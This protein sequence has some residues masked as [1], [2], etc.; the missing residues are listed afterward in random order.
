MKCLALVSAVAFASVLNADAAERRVS[1]DWSPYPFELYEFVPETQRVFSIAEG[2]AKADG[3]DSAAAINATIARCSAAGGGRVLVPAGT[4]RTGPVV[5]ASGVELHL[6]KGAV[7]EVI[8][9]SEAYPRLKSP[10][11][12]AEDRDGTM[13][14][15]FVRADRCRNVAI[16]GEG[17]LRGN[18]KWWFREDRIRKARPMFLWFEACTNIVLSGVKIRQAAFW[19]VHTRRCENVILR[20]LDLVCTPEGTKR[21]TNTDGMDIDSTRKVLIEGCSFNQ[22]DD[23][24]CMKSGKN[25]VGRRLGLPTEYVAVRNCRAMR[26]HGLLSIGSELSGGIRYVYMCDCEVPGPVFCFVR[27]KT[28]RAR[29]AFAHDI[30]VERVK[31][32]RTTYE[33]FRLETD[34][35]ETGG[36]KKPYHFTDIY[37]IT[38]R[39][40]ACD[41][42]PYA[43]SLSG[44]AEQPARNIRVERLRV[45]KLKKGF[46]DKIE[47]VDLSWV[48][49]D[50][51]RRL[52]PAV[53]PIWRAPVEEG[54]GAFTVERRGKAEGSVI[55]RDGRLVIRKTNDR[56]SIVVRAKKPISAKAG[57]TVR[58]SAK[59]SCANALPLASFASPRVFGVKENLG[60]SRADDA[61]FGS[62]GPRQ[63]TLVNTPAGTTEPKFGEYVLE[64]ADCGEA[65]TAIVVGGVRS[66]SVWS[67][68]IA[69]TA[70]AAD[71]AWRR[72]EARRRPKPRDCLISDADLDAALAK[73]TEHTAAVKTVAG[74]PRLVVDGEVAAPV[75]YKFKN[76]SAYDRGK[77]S[78][79]A[80]RMEREAGVDLQAVSVIF[81]RTRNYPNGFWT[82]DSFD[83]KGAVATVREAMR[84]SPKA[85][86]LVS[87]AVFPYPEFTLEHPD[88]AW[89]VDGGDFAYGNESVICGTTNN[90]AAL[91]AGRWAWISYA[92]PAWRTETKKCLAAF[93][94][95]LRR[96]GTS[97]RVIGLHFCG[98]RD[99]QFSPTDHPDRS[100]TMRRA[101]QARGKGVSLDFFRQRCGNEAEDD[102]AAFAKERF[103]KETVAVRWCL[104]AFN[105][106]YGGSYDIGAFAESKAIDI[107]C[108]QP[109]YI[110]RCP[111][112][113][114]GVRLPFAS[115]RAHGKLFLNEFDLRTSLA[116]DGASEPDAVALG[117]PNCVDMW[118][119]IYRRAAG[120]MIANGEGWWLYDMAGGWWDSPDYAA[121]ARGG[122]LDYRREL[123]GG[124]PVWR[125]E[126]AVLIDEESA[127]G[128]VVKRV[129]GR[130][131]NDWHAVLAA[132]G[133]P[134]ET[135]LAEDW[136]KR[137]ELADGIKAVAWF[138]LDA[139]DARRKALLD[140][141]EKRG[142]RVI[143]H[144]DFA[145][146]TGRDLHAQAR[147]AGAYVPS[148]EYG[149]QVDMNGSFASV[150]CLVPGAY[151][152]R[153]PTGETRRLDLVAGETRWLKKG[154]R[155]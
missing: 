136:L 2:G 8:E 130:S 87:V 152:F 46:A 134:Y 58:V 67:E 62:R 17:E 122:V 117:V 40:L 138:G 31:G 73:E 56:G 150:H 140:R 80:E 34:Y 119:S 137:P 61:H 75:F 91:P 102:L 125:P 90:P 4:W 96:T 132:S 133:V 141:L 131:F 71:E 28:N 118:R 120:Q 153:W 79:S 155:P 66:E 59:V 49:T 74:V 35:P 88:E 127:F 72:E 148:Q 30:T 129:K 47:N 106:G 55:V 121:A 1:V 20:G 89:R 112:V 27:V 111:G 21:Y 107:L 146:L 36:I 145:R 18:V 64:G 103:G 99:W 109:M 26:G 65:H 115:F 39:D 83:A 142:V 144:A 13:P 81:G 19:T 16:T 10:G 48:D 41:E 53:T 60:F 50:N 51:D 42:A 92:S 78:E 149:L 123:A 94:D 9:G 113:P 85:K 147:T 43:I 86:F 24:I 100:E 63:A 97:K 14:A 105:G 5:L 114:L 84:R 76:Y 45:K 37:D 52:V 33:V 128:M 68:W 104:A 139:A 25:E 29:G 7:L 95:E 110:D 3:S 143:R 15:P 44:Y 70:A 23:V 116:L 38:V 154:D 126:A 135:W 98:F 108:A 54:L 11:G 6:A 57:E 32:R 12:Y 22:D 82:K 101:W 124:T 151:E 77:W 69:E 93:I